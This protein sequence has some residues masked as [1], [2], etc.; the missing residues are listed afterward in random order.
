MNEPAES[1]PIERRTGRI[2]PD[3]RIAVL[4][5]CLDEAA[6]IG[7][8]IRSFQQALPGA[9]I[10]VYDNGSTD[11]TAAEAAAAGA[12]VRLE[13]RRGKGNVVRRMLADI[14]ADIYVLVDGDGTYDAA[15]AP[16]LIRAMLAG[17]ADMVVASRAILHPSAHR[18]GH[19]AGN[20][21]LTRLVGWLFSHP[22][23]DMLSG[24][25]VISRRFAK[26]FPALSHG[27]EIETELTVHALE[28]RLQM[29]EIA[30]PYGSRQRGSQSKLRTCRDG[31]R[32]V[33]TVLHLLKDE[34]PLPTL[35]LLGLALAAASLALAWPLVMTFLETGLVPRLP[36]AVLSASIMLLAFLS[37]IGGLMMDSVTTARR[38]VRRLAYLAQPP[39]S[40]LPF[41][42]SQSSATSAE[43]KSVG[44]EDRP[45]RRRRVVDRASS[46]SAR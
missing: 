36:T 14:D 20:W 25:R 46:W 39:L 32:I 17:D 1:S 23:V 13:P 9:S 31:T 33:A 44:P 6:A 29:L 18:P 4:I 21:M 11:G 34:R 8:V 35:G 24:Y 37:L 2:V 16:A 41:V 12:D 42:R 27:F 22:L 19:E 40:R 10:H 45:V 28:L 43:P 38:E 15:A 3:L 5:P 30:A 7:A 26:S